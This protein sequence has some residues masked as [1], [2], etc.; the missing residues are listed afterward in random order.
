MDEPTNYLDLASIDALQNIL[1]EYAGTVLF[2]SHDRA[3]VDAVADRLL[4]VENKQITE[5]TG[6]WQAWEERRHKATS[7]EKEAVN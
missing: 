4:I 6:N 3:F 5:F 1:S 2:V 7:A